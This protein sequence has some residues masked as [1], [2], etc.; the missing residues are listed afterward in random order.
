MTE[1]VRLDRLAKRF[2]PVHAVD[3][4]SFARGA[5]AR[6]LGFLG[7]NGA[8]KST[9]MRMLTGYITP[10]SGTASVMG[11][12]V[13]R[14]PIEAKRRIGY[15]PEGAP[16]YGDMTVLALSRA[17]SPRCAAST[18]PRRKRRIE[19][20]VARTELAEVRCTGR[21]RPSPRAS[22]AG[23]ASP[24]RSCTTR[25]SWSSTSRPTGS[26]RTRST[27]C[28]A[29]I[30]EMAQDKAIIISTHILEE[31]EAICTRA[32]DHRPR[33]GGRRRAARRR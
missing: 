24:R 6:C 27:A 15:L 26:T 29:L 12:D 1:M 31:V 4:V 20:A 11:F 5:G 14:R 32:V 30:Q 23:S 3:G 33:P 22:S 17:S 21:S 25:R 7:P 19:A 2:G 16:L 10:T 28:A 18:G 8:G 9:T 13:V